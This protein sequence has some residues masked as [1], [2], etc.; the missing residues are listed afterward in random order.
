MLQYYLNLTEANL[1]GESD[2]KLEYVLTQTYDIEDLQPKSLY[3]LAKQFA[4]LDSEQFIKYYNYFFV[5]YDTSATCSGKCKANQVCAITSLDHISYVD[6]L[7][8]Y[9]IK[10]YP[11]YFTVSVHR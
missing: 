9:Y 10:H 8:Q 1:K 3:A 4:I 6:C 11:K 7:K 5:S 2:W